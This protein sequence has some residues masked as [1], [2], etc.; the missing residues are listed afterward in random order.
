M[1]KY[2][3]TLTESERDRLK[4][5]I[6]KRKANSQ[7]VKRAYVLLAADENQLAWF[8]TDEIYVNPQLGDRAEPLIQVPVDEKPEV[9]G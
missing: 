8:I 9:V 4:A 2:H 7:S 5:I 6:A 1:K 3:V